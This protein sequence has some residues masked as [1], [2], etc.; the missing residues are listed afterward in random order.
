MLMGMCFSAMVQ[1]DAKK[2]GLQFRARVQIDMYNDL[3]QRRLAGEKLILNKAMEYPF[4]HLSALAATAPEQQIKANILK[5]HE[6]QVAVLN[7]ERLKQEARHQAAC[8]ALKTKPTKK[9][10][11]EERVSLNKIKKIGADLEKH[12]SLEFLSEDEQRIFPL[13]Y[14]TM[15]CLDEAGQR[16][17]RPVRYLMRPHD[18]DASFDTKFSGCYNARLDNLESVPWW[19]SSLGQR[20]GL[21]L[22]KKFYENVQSNEYS[23]HHVLSPDKKTAKSL[24]ICFEPDSSEYMLIPTLWD[25][26]E[27]KGQ[28]QQNGQQPLYSAALITDEPALEVAQAGHNRTPIFLNENA[29]DDWLSVG[30]SNTAIREILSR[31]ERPY[32]R[33]LILS[34]A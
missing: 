10:A 30:H 18:R 11:T 14:F 7:E 26:W 1:Q 16:V 32:Y 20:H 21:I 12:R 19:K 34:A 28:G 27:P 25:K 13:H 3:F 6:H 24:V 22:V 31:R 23:K 5:W 33:H 9:A 15:L 29:I 17:V 2:V 8:A 4:T